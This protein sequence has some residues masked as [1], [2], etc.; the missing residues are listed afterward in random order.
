MISKILAPAL[1]ASL[2]L[3]GCMYVPL[4]SIPR[5]VTGAV[6]NGAAVLQLSTEIAS[7][8]FQTQAVI[9]PYVKTD[10]HHL[11]LELFK[12]NPETQAETAVNDALGKAIVLEIAGARIDEPVLFTKLNANT[13]YRI[14]AKAYLDAAETT[15]ISTAN[16]S[17][18]TDISIVQDDRPTLAKLKVQLI[19]KAFDAQGSAGI[20]VSSGSLIPAG[21]ETMTQQPLLP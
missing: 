2:F 9:N 5:L 4:G 11:K 16:A 3:G 18:S 17:S 21:T 15:L 1:A 13:T 10:V 12:V 7:G 6:A 8:G 19:D 14:K 20:D